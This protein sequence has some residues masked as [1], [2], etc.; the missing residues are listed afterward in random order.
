VKQ[1]PE[2]RYCQFSRAVDNRASK[3]S[4][5]SSRCESHTNKWWQPRM[6]ALRRTP[7]SSL[8]SRRSCAESLRRSSTKSSGSNERVP[9]ADRH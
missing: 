9:W 5:D 1:T 4:A 2:R 7:G 8:A 3:C 6:R